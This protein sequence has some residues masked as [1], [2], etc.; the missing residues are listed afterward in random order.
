MGF[1]SG[2]KGLIHCLLYS[3]LAVVNEVLSLW[4]NKHWYARSD[5][6]T[7]AHLNTQVFCMYLHTDF[8]RFLGSCIVIYFLVK[9][10]GCTKSQIYF[11]W[12][13][14]L[15]VS[16]GLSVHHQESNTAHT[17]SGICHTGP[18]TAC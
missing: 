13:N 12:N 9:P 7:E 4:S 10:T 15:H 5:I 8:W 6:L 3:R 17:A 14:T 1:N 2:F 11:I 16:D 18:V